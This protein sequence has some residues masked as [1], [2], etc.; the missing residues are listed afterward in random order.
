VA[1]ALVA[2]VGGQFASIEEAARERTVQSNR[3]VTLLEPQTV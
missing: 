3:T 1:H 2:R